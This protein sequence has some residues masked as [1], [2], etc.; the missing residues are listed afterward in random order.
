MKKIIP[1]IIEKDES[2]FYIFECSL[3]HGCYAQGK[4]LREAEKNFQEVLSLVLEEPENRQIWDNYKPKSFTFKTL[5]Y[6]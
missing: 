6:A 3:F 1:I 4:T 2:G 5:S